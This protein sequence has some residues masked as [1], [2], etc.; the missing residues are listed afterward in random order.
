MVRLFS[1]PFGIWPGNML[2]EKMPN[3]VK[4]FLKHGPIQAFIVFCGE[5]NYLVRRNKDIDF[6]TIGDVCITSCLTVL[7]FSRVIL[8]NFKCY[9]V[10]W[11]KFFKTF[12]L[13]NFKNNGYNY[14]NICLK[15]DTVSHYFTVL[16]IICTMIGMVLFNLSPICNNVVNGAYTTRRDENTTLRFSVLYEFPGFKPEDHFIITT[17]L[18]FYF[19]YA[20]TICICAIDLMLVLMV[21]QIIGHIEVLRRNLDDFPLPKDVVIFDIENNN[22]RFEI[23]FESFNARE[24][25]FIHNHLEESV[26]HHRFIVNFVSEMSS[27]FGPMMGINYLYQLVGC[28]FL[29]LE[30]SQ[31]DTQA[32][33]RFGPLTLISVAQLVEISVIFEVVGSMSEKLI[34]NVYSL[35]WQYMNMKN[36]RTMFIFFSNV[37]RTMHV[38]CMGVTPIGVQSMAAILKT[39]FSYFTFLRSM[40]TQ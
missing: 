14:K 17:I 33:A 39:S 8:P 13:R 6:F 3:F 22:R 25:D 16:M 20:C 15:M 10:I 5:I 19:S 30:C 1:Y 7:T 4:Y 37:Q 12:H 35:P 21:F 9:G 23:S 34:D 40:D 18:N 28:C 31:L 26:N 11:R 2:D 32:L 38:T 36:Q 29:L 27:V 24:N